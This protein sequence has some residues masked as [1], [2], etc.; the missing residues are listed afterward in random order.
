MISAA[1]SSKLTWNERRRKRNITVQILPR[2][3]ITPKPIFKRYESGH[4][5]VGIE[6]WRQYI[7]DKWPVVTWLSGKFFLP[8]GEQFANRDSKLLK[9]EM[10]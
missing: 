6:F 10:V 2:F 7:D 3:M 5:D 9:N 8:D 1:F 4:I